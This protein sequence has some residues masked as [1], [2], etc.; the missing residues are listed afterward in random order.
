MIQGEEFAFR[1]KGFSWASNYGKW[2]KNDK[3]RERLFAVRSLTVSPPLLSETFKLFTFDEEPTAV[4][5]PPSL[6]EQEDGTILAMCITGTSS[7]DS[8]ASWIKFL[9]RQNPTLSEIP[10]V[11]LLRT[12]EAEVQVYDEEHAKSNFKTWTVF[13]EYLNCFSPCC[14]VGHE[15]IL[16]FEESKTGKGLD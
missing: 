15:F 7:K 4:S 2:T 3:N 13:F 12:P 10:V 1:S 8:L 9:E 6:H 11:F 14:T 16:D 5:I